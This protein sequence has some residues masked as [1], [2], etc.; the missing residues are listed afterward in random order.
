M[1]SIVNIDFQPADAV[2]AP[3]YVAVGPAYC[4]DDGTPAELGGGVRGAWVG[5]PS[6]HF[7]DLAPTHPD[8]LTRD[9]VSW[10]PRDPPETFRIQPIEPGSYDLTIHAALPYGTASQTVVD[11]D[12]DD[13]GA[14]DVSLTIQT[15]RGEQS[16]T[17]SVK[18]SAAGVLSFTVDGMGGATGVLTGLNL[19]AAD[20]D[21]TR[22]E[23]IADL[24][25]V[26]AQSQSVTLRWTAPADDRGTGGRVA[27]YDV[28][29][30][31]STLNE[32]NWSAAMRPGP[33]PSPS[34][35]GYQELFVATGLTPGR[36]Y[37][38]AVISADR[39]GNV[40]DISNVVEVTT[41]KRDVASPAQ[42]TDFRVAACGPSHAVLRWTAVGD[43]GADGKA[44]GYDVRYSTRPITNEAEF[45]AAQ[46]VVGLRLPRPSGAT[47][48]ALATGLTGGTQYYFAVRVTD[49]SSNTSPLSNVAA[50]TTLEADNV[51]PSGITDLAVVAVDAGSVALGWT[52][53]GDDGEHG[54]AADYDL[55]YSTKPIANEA[56]FAEAE[57]FTGEPAPQ[58]P[59]SAERCVVWGLQPN[60]EYCFAVKAGDDAVPPNLSVLSNMVRAQTAP[61]KDPTYALSNEFRLERGV[62]LPAASQ[63]RLVI[64][65]IRVEEATIVRTQHR[66]GP[67]HT[68]SIHYALSAPVPYVHVWLELSTDGG[69]TWSERRIHAVGAVGMVR[70]GSG[71]VA[72]WLI[73]GDHGHRCRIRIR[74][75]DAPAT[76]SDLDRDENKYPRP[77]PWDRYANLERLTDRRDFDFEDVRYQLP[78]LDFYRS[79]TAGQI[80]AGFARVRFFHDPGTY[81]TNPAYF[82]HC[83]YLESPDGQQKWVILQGDVQ[84][85][86]T[87][88]V[89]RWREQIHETFGIPR[90]HI[91]VLV[92]HVHNHADRV[93]GIDRFPTKLLQAAMAN[94]HPVEIG[95]LNKDM[96][97]T[98]N[99][100]RDLLLAPDRAA[101]TFTNDNGAQVLPIQWEYNAFWEPIA[102]LLD[103]SAYNSKYQR[104]FDCPLDSY[105][106][107]IVFRHAATHQM[108]G[109][110][111]KFTAHPCCGDYPGDLPRAVMDT[112]Q[113]RFGPNVE[114]MYTSGFAGNHRPLVAQN[115][116][117]EQGSLR[118]AKTFARTLADALPDMEFQRLTQLGMV[119]GY[120]T[121]GAYVDDTAKTGT[122]PNRLG[123]GVHV[124]RF[125]DIYLSTL[126]GEAPSEQG[127]YIR[128][129]T[130]DLKHMYNAYGNTWYEYYTWGRWFDI[131]H[132]EGA[133]QPNRF[134][135]FRMAQEIVRGVNILDQAFIEQ[136]RPDCAA[137]DEPVN[138]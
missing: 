99:V 30:T 108:T 73:D 93:P 47:E 135:S 109:V 54:S 112:M 113:E 4:W 51:P 44:A 12:E 132:Y 5:S 123:V 77:A 91:M 41:Q 102:A 3:G 69:Q 137:Q 14:P 19:V 106:Q 122:D 36:A 39:W 92:T 105:L 57:R 134:E 95:F 128:A 24:V 96:G 98:Y 50:G 101:S 76:Y 86:W 82:L 90:D 32:S 16:K 117:P 21:D 80:Q 53:V 43:D 78:K 8:P 125:N 6:A 9:C 71:K 116:P 126:P 18:V 111:V 49:E 20:P 63:G 31:H 11:V 52:A 37:K 124:F 104:Y 59:G 85:I 70:P 38:M 17:V 55:R 88:T 35:P 40:S 46:E 131:A 22:P 23:A 42:I 58:E 114:V 110:L 121:F 81:M 79:T 7:R 130:S 68:G 103:G 84:H 15:P 89:H 29:C 66:S 87:Y 136:A 56:S 118:V 119:A 74:A 107:M 48:T 133:D 2:T 1:V 97:T 94:K 67:V 61:P 100:H 60:T 28:R 64:E 127:L 34:N 27:H 10:D 83:L 25:V 75:Q 138:P 13:D 129:R 115:C 62:R 45:G 120:D 72:R 65:D 33:P 26:E